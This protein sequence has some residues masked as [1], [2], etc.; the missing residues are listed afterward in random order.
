MHEN[1]KGQKKI[2]KKLWIE[3]PHPY[4]NSTEDKD[5]GLILL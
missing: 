4:C 5:E 3:N 1:F 2:D